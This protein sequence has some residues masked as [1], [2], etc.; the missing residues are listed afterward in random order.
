MNIN[1]ARVFVRSGF[2]SAMLIQE[3]GKWIRHGGIVAL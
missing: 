2:P 1:D 3:A